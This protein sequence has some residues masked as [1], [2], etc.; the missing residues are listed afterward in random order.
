MFTFSRNRFSL[1]GT[2]RMVPDPYNAF[3]RKGLGISVVRA[4]WEHLDDKDPLTAPGYP[5]DY[6]P[7]AWPAIEVP[8]CWNMSRPELRYY[9]GPAWYFKQFRFEKRPAYRYF[10]Y[11]E[12]ANYHTKVWFNGHV[13]GENEGGFTPFW[14][15]VTEH[16]L[17]SNIVLVRVDNTRL[18]EG[19]PT[20][21]SDFFNFGG[22]TRPVH[23]VAVPRDHIVN[24]KVSTR[25]DG[26]KTFVRFEVW[27]DGA[28]KGAV[29]VRIPEANFVDAIPRKKRGYYDAEFE[30]YPELW[31][32]AKPRLYTV[33]LSYGRDTVS[34]QIGF[35]EMR[36]EGE[37][38]LLNGK[39]LRLYGIG[40]H[41]EADGKGRTLD[42]KDV[43]Q[44]FQWLRELHCN[45][46]RLVHYPHTE[47][48]PRTA[49][50][51]GILL[52]EEIPVY[53]EIAYENK[54]TLANA[55]HQMQRM[56][57]R[58]WNRASVG[59]WCAG[60][61]TD[62]LGHRGRNSFMASLIEFA[63]KLDQT[64]PISAACLLNDKNLDAMVL[65]DPL[66]AKVDVVGVN[67]Y[68]G[69]YAYAVEDFGKWR[70]K[71]V[72]YP[73]PVIVTEFGGGAA[74][75]HHGDASERWTEEYQA[76]IYRRQLEM[77]DTLPRV[78]GMLPWGLF[79]F[80]T[81]RRAN[82]WQRGYNRKGIVSNAGRK[83]L[84][85]KVLSDFYAEKQGI[86]PRPSRSERPSKQRRSGTRRGRG[87]RGGRKS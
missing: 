5:L 84:A 77:L 30:V 50:K 48:M 52:W 31:T 71:D 42:E 83:K 27:T 47:L 1:N 86:R 2:W 69:W 29:T 19:V 8:S 10:L 7:E 11:F 22:I 26:A 21:I 36:V 66:A 43:Q 45:F 54:A 73:K 80:L 81:P 59:F 61:E 55:K 6:S 3:E 62:L 70:E 79:D 4:I 15:E 33:E 74:P 14:F 60:N 72:K 20:L 12:A 44:R 34:D 41:E 58:D 78:K 38:I 56:I 24:F 39:P 85:F 49:D 28:A 51:E 68:C 32:M 67:Q 46:A 9:E 18:A 35:R 40:F 64:R 76:D 37:E 87:R 13:L 75:G 65:D 25:L 63:R 16:L 82:R 23:V 17:M 53:W 57:E